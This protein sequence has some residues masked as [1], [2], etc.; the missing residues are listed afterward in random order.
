M[1]TRNENPSQTSNDNRGNASGST[2]PYSTANDSRRTD[3]PLKGAGWNRGFDHLSGQSPSMQGQTG[4]YYRAALQRSSQ[5]RDSFGRGS[6]E[7]SGYG[8]MDSSSNE[9]SGNAYGM[10]EVPGYGSYAEGERFSAYGRGGQTNRGGYTPGYDSQEG[11]G[12]QTFGYGERAEVYGDAR[13]T[14]GMGYGQQGFRDRS[15][16]EDFSRQEGER[17][18]GRK[19][20]SEQPQHRGMFAGIL[21]RRD[22]RTRGTRG[23]WQKEAL[24]A[25]EIMT[26]NVRGVRKTQTLRE[27]AV[28]MREENVGIVPVLDEN[29]RLLGLLTDRDIVVRA[30]PEGKNPLELRVEDLMTHEVEAVHPEERVVDVIDLMGQKQIRRVPVVDRNDQLVGIIAMADI[31]IKADTD[32]DLQDALEKISSRRSFW[33][34]IFA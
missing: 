22:E 20:R 24:T 15:W 13:G 2:P 17:G 12:E 30:L 7:T 3:E 16:G 31:A 29:N 11:R 25:R 19:G 14:T 1:A 10:G 33:S 18:L 21:G 4:S 34:R 5:Q 23:R 6:S 9:G 8:N 28:I 27:A 32:E 26:R